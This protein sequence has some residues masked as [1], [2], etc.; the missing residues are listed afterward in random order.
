MS[1]Q[2]T[3]GR[4]PAGAS[5][6]RRA[7]PGLH[8]G[9]LRSAARVPDRPALAVGGQTLSYAELHARSAAIAATLDARVPD[10]VP[11]LVAIY[12]HRAVT[13]FAGVLGV[14]MSGRAYV[15]LN[16]TLPAARNRLMLERSGA[17]MIVVDPGSLDQV[18]EV[19]EGLDPG[20]LVLAPDDAAPAPV[21]GHDVVTLA[22][23][24]DA[25][26]WDERQV[27]ENEP[28]YVLFTS[29]ST[30]IPKGV[31]V[32]HRNVPPLI[33][34]QVERYALTE[35]D[36]IS[37]THELTFDVSVWDMFVTWQVGACLCC[38]STKELIKPGGFIRREGITIWFSV[39]STAVFMKRL[40]MLK[41]DSYPTLRYSLFAGEPLPVAVAEAWLEAAPASAVENLYGPTELTIL[42]MGHRWQPG[43]TA[44][45]GVV[46]IGGPLA[47]NRP[48]VVDDELREVEPGAIGELI[49]AGPQVTLGYWRDPEQ[50]ATAFVVPPGSEEVHYRTGDRVR[51]PSSAGVP[52]AYLGRT[53]SQVK[54]RGVRVELGEVEA[55][56]REATGVD[57]V[58]AVAWPR[59]LTGADGIVAFVGDRGVD[60]PAVK[61]ELEGRLP[62]HMV[63]RRFELLDQLPLGASG[64]FDRLALL[65]SL[66]EN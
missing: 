44:E 62:A 7:G 51:R 32:A 37:Q 5:D 41:P 14:L 28:A 1:E 3:A 31:T 19:L 23:L 50:T 12:S 54:V 10:G 8:S 46:P 9:F 22:D 49:V 48:L 33:D 39:P 63:P 59:T 11:P 27:D 42:C 47:Q 26:A 45:A 13:A 16:P 64:K 65:R 20:F 18:E 24:E 57:A 43:D 55:A 61:A 36:R 17:R 40:G 66:E 60:V 4:Q 56:V 21:D 6:T 30:G 58:I 25:A 29:G 34:D 2:S 38:P 15:P 35:D 52:M 53:D